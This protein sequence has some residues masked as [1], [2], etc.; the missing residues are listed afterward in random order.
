MQSRWSE[1]EAAKFVRKHAKASSEDL[2]LRTYSARLLGAEPGLVL[3]G[4]GNTSLK[5]EVPDIFAQNRPV[6]YVKASGLDLAAIEPAGHTALDLE[7]LRRLGALPSLTDAAM[8]NEF[9]TH[10]VR[11]AAATPSI[12]TLV[13]AFLPPRFIDHTHADAILALTNQPSG[14]KIAAEALGDE[15]IVLDYVTPGFELA[16]AS[17][18]AFGAQP[19]A[20][21][22]VWVRHGL[23]TWGGTARES[24]EATIA[25]ITRAE[26]Y[27][28]RRSK[29]SLVVSASTAVETARKRWSVVAPIAR[30]LLARAT[31]EAD[32]PHARVIL[33]PLINREVLDFVDSTSARDLALTPPLTSDHLIRT[34]P[35]P[36]WLDSPHF[37][38]AEK[39]RTEL[40]EAIRCYA[41]N[42]Q[43]YFA[44]QRSRLPA[45]VEPF[46]P[47][48]RV[49]LIPGL[50][51]L[52]A[53]KDAVAAGIVRDITAHTLAAK[54]RIYAMGSYQG[55]DEAELFDMEYRSL[56]HA[57]LTRGDEKALAREVALVTG[58]AGAIGSAICEELLSNGC[59][60]AATDLPGAALDSLVEDL[61]AV[62]D[63]RIVGTPL[64]VTDPQFVAA[65]F[66]AVIQ[67][68][69]GV[70][71]VVINAGIAHISAI[72][73]LSLET[74]RKL[75]RV[76]QEG[77]LLML[78]EAARHFRAQG[79]GG[80]IILISTKNVAAPS[81]H[82]A[83]YS[84][85]KAAAH[86]LA[87]IA[88]LEL[89]ELGVRVNMIAPD[90]IFSHGA[91][92]S[93]LWA[94]VGPDRMKARGM[95]EKEL[96]EYYKNRN[97]LKIQ[98]TARH[99]G[100][101]VV[102]FATR[103]TPTTG[104][105]LPVDGGLPDAAPR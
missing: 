105:T 24:Y 63:Q 30:G 49:L 75:E 67:E 52:C 42:Y 81:A 103:Q 26:E 68:W 47:D 76:N 32:C 13:H 78:R 97:L 98:I 28:A 3:H 22:M 55:L 71:L 73:D 92:K 48:P 11:A 56:Q 60:V 20:R 58:A 95:N 70:D 99:V 6:I 83:A 17:A 5:S 10:L 101:A 29:R 59:H 14:L 34:K 2:A 96:E 79:T 85:T 86:Q 38:D 74:F 1:T 91:R 64:D 36:L 94:E 27:I 65:G 19:T 69:G 89:A 43:A 80:D 25:L 35:W 100:R 37:D 57:K 102:F 90:A 61:S 15:V 16:K 39:L 41:T 54:A 53:G 44:R 40:A 93:G 62:Y 88:S 51:A 8:V 72:A 12:E 104:A 18:A 9:R 7:Y 45:G 50:G 66:E 46:D 77:T 87:R 4:G 21:G 23:V 33:R 31:G 82:F 84:A